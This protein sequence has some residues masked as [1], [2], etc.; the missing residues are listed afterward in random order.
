MTSKP[1]WMTS[2]SPTADRF[3]TPSATRFLG[4]TCLEIVLGFEH[5]AWRFILLR[6]SAGLIRL[7]SD[8][9]VRLSF[10]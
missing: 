6:R 10:D 4:K 1:L 3:S 2:E 9:V 7:A 8:L 5:G